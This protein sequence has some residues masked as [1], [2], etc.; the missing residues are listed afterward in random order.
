VIALLAGGIVLLGGVLYTISRG[1]SKGKPSRKKDRNALMR[2]A[3]RAL[4]QNPKD[5]H[6]LNTLADIYYSE[7]QWE[8]AAKTYGILMDLVAT[9]PDLNEH[10]ITLR[11][12]LASMQVG[13]YQDAYKSLML[14]RKDHEDQF[15]INYNLGQLEFKRKNYER[16]ANLLKSAHEKR[17]EHLGTAKYLGQSYYRLKRYRDSISLLRRVTEAEPDDKESIF[18][19]GQAYYES[20]QSDQALRI[21]GHLRADPTY[22]PRAS[23]IAGSLHL[24]SRLYDEAEMDFQIGLRHQNIT[25]EVMLELKYRLAA[26]YTR[27]QQL[28]K[29]L[30]VLQ[31]IAQV[32][33]SY[34]DVSEQLERSRELAGNRNLQTFLMAPTSEFVGLCRRIVTNYF[35]RSKTKI[36]DIT[37]GR[38]EY[39]DVLAEIN[40][41]KWEDTVL[42]R[43]V[44]S[45]GA[46]GELVLRDLH[47]RTK[48]LHAGRGLCICAGTFS[49]GAVAYVEA[50]LI[51]LIDKEHLTKLLKRV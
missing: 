7:Q 2:E 37:V 17:P 19:L 1:S 3:N 13:E 31:E 38:S 46:V 43:F 41:A 50:R 29:A 42:F 44:R 12:G 49:E 23:L 33:P 24:K 30:Q 18:Y 14:A 28:E 9:N 15:E 6:A 25:P 35:P 36:T 4:S 51:D 8:K 20:G 21:F 45:S 5:A 27:K 16:A 32:N 11:H 22:G 34:K 40:T 26:T 10:L 47:S 48:E 39:T